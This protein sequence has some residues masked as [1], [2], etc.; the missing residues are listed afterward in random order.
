MKA[1][2]DSEQTY[3]LVPCEL[4]IPETIWVEENR[5]GGYVAVSKPEDP[6][7][8]GKLVA[9][10]EP[11]VT[12]VDD[13][14]T[15]PG[16]VGRIPSSSCS[17]PSIVADMLRALDVHPGHAV[18]EVGTGTGWNAAL[19]CQQ[20]GARGRVV[21]VEID[22]ELAGAARAVLQRIGFPA[23]VIITDGAEGHPSSA[24]FDRIISTAA[25][26]WQ[27]P[28]AWVQQTQPG[29]LIVT[30][31]GTSYH[32]GTLLRLRVI[33]DDMAVGRFGGNLAFM[34]LRAQC[35]PIWV[36]N[37]TLDDAKTSTTTLS[38]VE[39]GQA[40]VS[41]DGSF[42]VGLHVSDCRVHID[43]DT[44]E[45]QHAVWLC[46]GSSLARVVVDIGSSSHEVCQRGPRGLWDEVEAAYRW[47]RDVGNPE[48]TRFGLTV[49][50]QDQVVWLD[51]PANTV[52]AGDRNPR[53]REMVPR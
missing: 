32:N 48:H 13:G 38:S 3:P 34:R 18:L 8:W 16:S 14:H 27:V 41:F 12:Q 1:D 26:R 10:D 24:P 21:S 44:A 43:E 9:A 2:T 28:R 46:D 17:K 37:D 45:G 29:G 47:W 22:A 25:V 52:P 7:Q 30:P 40:V 39:I 31:W 6:G 49:T 15:L 42:A 33:D 36:D 35:G 50:S 4:F 20:V 19:L 23:L 51:N 5:V 53:R 11:V